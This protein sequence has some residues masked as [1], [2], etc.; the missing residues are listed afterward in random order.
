MILIHCSFCSIIFSATDIFDILRALDPGKA[1]GP[2]G[3]PG[4]LLREC[5][6]ELSDSLT[7][8]FNSSLLQG[9]VPSA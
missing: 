2:D 9:K 3:I 1:C 5:A 7:V 4:K 8:I 6:F